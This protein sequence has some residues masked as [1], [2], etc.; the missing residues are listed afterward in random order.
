MVTATT[1]GGARPNP[2]NARW[3]VL[4][5]QNKKFICLWKHYPHASNN[6]MEIGAAIAGLTFLPPGMRI[7]LSTDS[8]YVEKGIN[9]W[10]PN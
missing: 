6:A 9:E 4:I 7:W 10:T 2:G 8:Q 1:D 3:G 5:R